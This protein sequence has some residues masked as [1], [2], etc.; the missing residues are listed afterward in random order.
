MIT[1]KE[2]NKNVDDSYSLKK[3]WSIF[4]LH[5]GVPMSYDEFL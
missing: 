2:N 5:Y 3:L 1:V 4:E